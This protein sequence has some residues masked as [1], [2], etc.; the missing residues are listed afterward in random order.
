MKFPK[1]EMKES[2]K[3]KDWVIYCKK[4]GKGRIINQQ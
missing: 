4:R 2:D 3:L 1:S